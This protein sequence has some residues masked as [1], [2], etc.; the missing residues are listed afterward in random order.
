[1]KDFSFI[2][3]FCFGDG[4]AYIFIT[5]HDWKK[6]RRNQYMKTI[7]YLERLTDNAS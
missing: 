2:G 1:M 6:S 3:R 5:L 7:S 4:L